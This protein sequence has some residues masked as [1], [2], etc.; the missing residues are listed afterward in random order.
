MDAK[1]AVQVLKEAIALIEKE[2]GEFVGIY[3]RLNEVQ[4]N[5]VE[6]SMILPAW[7]KFHNHWVSGRLGFPYCSCLSSDL[8]EVFMDWCRMHSAKPLTMTKFSSLISNRETKSKREVVIDGKRST[9]MIFVVGKDIEGE[10]VKK[11]C[12]DFRASIVA[13]GIKS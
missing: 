5:Y 11:Q 1:E 2:D 13:A 6:K 10:S 7:V 12:I 4:I 9:Y 3:N 8:Y